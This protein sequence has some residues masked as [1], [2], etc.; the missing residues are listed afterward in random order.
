MKHTSPPIDKRRYEEWNH[1]FIREAQAL[2]AEFR[3]SPIASFSALCYTVPM[4]KGTVQVR[5][6]PSDNTAIIEIH[7]P[8]EGHKLAIA[9]PLPEAL[10]FSQFLSAANEEQAIAAGQFLP[11]EKRRQML[12]EM[13]E[14]K[15]RH[16]ARIQ[17]EL[18]DLD[19]SEPDLPI[20]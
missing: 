7:R 4:A 12:Q 15:T 5:V 13:L 19:A 16:L 3:H 9:L 17:Q 6:E 10:R 20:Q 1:K 11:P 14:L 2:N 18:R 8:D